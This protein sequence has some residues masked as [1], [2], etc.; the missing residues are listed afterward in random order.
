MKTNLNILFHS[1]LLLFLIGVIQQCTAPPKPNKIVYI[2][3]YHK[4][5]PSSD[6]IMAG[7]MENMTEDN[8]AV[9]SYYMDTKRNTNPDYIAAKANQLLDSILQLEPDV[10]VVSD[11]NA[12]KYIVKPHLDVLD[13][14]VVFC[15]VNWSAEEYDLPPGQVTG[16]LEILPIKSV[17]QTIKFRY[18]KMTNLLV[19]SENTTTSRKEEDLLHDLFQEL[20]LTVTF[21]LVDHFEQW[22]AAF[23]EGNENYDII[24]IP[25]HASI[26]GWDHD[27]AVD[28]ISKNIKIPVVTCEDFMMPYVV[29]GE[30]KIAE[31]HGI[32]AANTVKEII[33]GADPGN[34][35]VSRNIQSN[36]YLN[37]KLARLIGFDP[38]SGLVKEVRIVNGP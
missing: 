14:P 2:N 22:Q 28:F 17:L 5:H 31:E 29:Y 32:W 15:G 1:I 24:Y 19:L 21:K 34:I 18:P 7:F 23:L 6:E 13:M 25:T 16:I 26:K 38:D 10:L 30:T 9:Y 4:G 20:N 11:D 36:A 35:P 37:L 33:S 27:H 12:V 3:S 8:F